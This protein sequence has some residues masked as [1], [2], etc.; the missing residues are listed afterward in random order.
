MQQPEPPIRNDWA[1]FIEELNTLFGEADLE[2]SSEQ[3][4]KRLKMQDNHHVN[5]YMTSFSEHA[6]Y[7]HWNEAALYDA[8]YAGL[9]ETL[10]DQLLTV[11]RPT[12]LEDLKRQSLWADNRYWERHN[13]HQNLQSTHITPTTPA[14]PKP[15]SRQSTKKVVDPLQPDRKN[16]TGILDV[17][18]KLTEAEKERQKTKGLCPY[19]RELSTCHSK[20]CRY[21]E[22]INQTAQATF[23]LEGDPQIATIAEISETQDQSDSE[24]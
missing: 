2:Q 24:N 19:C 6:S 20:D 1:L 23:T 14:T 5:R 12:T 16:L 7:T 15:E 22:P 3:A 9:A 11:E 17:M 18:G 13:E 4:L 10:K 21:K 8:F